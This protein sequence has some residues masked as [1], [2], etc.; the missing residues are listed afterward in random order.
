[1]RRYLKYL[2]PQ[3]QGQSQ[4]IQGNEGEEI[5]LNVQDVCPISGHLE[6]YIVSEGG[7]VVNWGATP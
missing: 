2:C 6:M 5:P 3:V 7:R 1:M 4:V